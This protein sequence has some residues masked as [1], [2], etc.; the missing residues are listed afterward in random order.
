[1]GSVNITFRNIV[2]CRGN[3]IGRDDGVIVDWGAIGCRREMSMD[4]TDGKC[5]ISKP[6]DGAD[7]E[8]HYVT[9][10]Y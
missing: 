5:N 3:M 4:P 9:R 6:F 1:M 7:G 2:V 10:G 8:I